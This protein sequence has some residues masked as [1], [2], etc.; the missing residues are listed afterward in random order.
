MVAT[1]TTLAGKNSRHK[2]HRALRMA[3][4]LSL[5]SLVLLGGCAGGSPYGY[6]PQ[7]ADAS[8]GAAP[9]STPSASSI[10]PR[11]VGR[12]P[13]RTAARLAPVAAPVPRAAQATRKR[14]ALPLASASGTREMVALMPEV[15]DAQE[16]AA[17]P[18]P[19]TIDNSES[20]ALA[21]DS[22]PAP[23]TFD[24]VDDM[25]GDIVG[26]IEAGR[27]R[28]LDDPIFRDPGPLASVVVSASGVQVMAAAPAQGVLPNEQ[29]ASVAELGNDETLIATLLFANGSPGVGGR[30]RDILR[31]V[32]RIQKEDGRTLT[33]VGHASGRTRSMD[34]TAQKEVNMRISRQRGESVAR[35]LREFGVAETA[36]RVIPMADNQ[37][38][39]S[40]DL[41]SGEAGNRRVEV[42]LGY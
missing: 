39:F 12:D 42:Y 14:P 3:A 8:L 29:D 41:P 24:I 6:A 22:E 2:P 40:E 5:V 33:L 31:E 27:A 18:S 9:I 37:P 21:P 26:D 17:P 4:V 15:D 32:A 38:L 11:A 34:P 36:L 35:V 10:D 13:I 16:F 25:V 23:Y 20:V 30:E 1:I 19:L 28:P 7:F